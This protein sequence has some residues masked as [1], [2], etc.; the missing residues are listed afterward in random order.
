[1]CQSK[2]VWF[3][4]SDFDGN[5]TY[6]AVDHIKVVVKQLSGHTDL[7]LNNKQA[8]AL[9]DSTRKAMKFIC[10][11]VIGINKKLF[12]RQDKNGFTYSRT[13]T[14]NQN[15]KFQV[16]NSTEKHTNAVLSLLS[17][18]R[19]NLTNF[20]LNKR[21]ILTEHEKRSSFVPC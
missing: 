5:A 17:W 16:V 7:G 2:D 20:V 15:K 21:K 11:D 14:E 13:S 9:T 19:Q 18:M 10:D 12:E 1:M 4:L 3:S 6:D 8:C